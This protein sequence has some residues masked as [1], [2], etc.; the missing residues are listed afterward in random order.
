MIINLLFYQ[1]DETV[2]KNET[3]TAPSHTSTHTQDADIHYKDD[4][5]NNVLNDITNRLINNTVKTP[6][7]ITINVVNTIQ[8]DKGTFYVFLIFILICHIRG[9]DKTI[10]L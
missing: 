2:V 4:R 7:A 3:D 9:Y 1:V 10:Y 8:Q 6:R 5:V